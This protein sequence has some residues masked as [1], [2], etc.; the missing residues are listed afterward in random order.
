MKQA[1]RWAVVPCLLREAPPVCGDSGRAEFPLLE[2]AGPVLTLFSP[3]ALAQGSR[4]RAWTRGSLQGVG[5]WTQL[6]THEERW[7]FS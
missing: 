5:G 1:Q 4:S 2:P 6:N 3:Q 7:S